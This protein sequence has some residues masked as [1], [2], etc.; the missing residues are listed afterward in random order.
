MYYIFGEATSCWYKDTIKYREDWKISQKYFM[1]Y[2][3]DIDAS[4]FIKAF[5]LWHIMSYSMKSHADTFSAIFDLKQLL[6]MGSI[7]KLPIML[8]GLA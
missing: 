2:S 8:L 7:A 5:I 3:L 6:K 1:I 4:E